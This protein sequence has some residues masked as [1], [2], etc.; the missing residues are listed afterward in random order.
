MTKQKY[1]VIKPG[2]GKASGLFM[3]TFAHYLV[4][5]NKPG[6]HYQPIYTIS[7][8][9]HCQL[10]K[11]KGFLR[12]CL[13]DLSLICTVAPQSSVAG[14]NKPQSTRQDKYIERPQH[15]CWSTA[16][17]LAGE[18]GG[19]TEW[20]GPECGSLEAIEVTIGVRGPLWPELNGKLLHTAAHCF[21]HKEKAFFYLVK[22]I[23]TFLPDIFFF[24]C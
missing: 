4:F 13:T 20:D 3:F 8:L 19:L 23:C 5:H 7:P 6:S 14:A 16:E 2:E 1:Q 11:G 12:S 10:N 18:A 24:Y 17:S 15:C 22:I 9:L 21:N